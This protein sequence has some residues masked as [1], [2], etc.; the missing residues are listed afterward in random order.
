MSPAAARP[1]H[2]AG[3]WYPSNPTAL[4]AQL[5]AAIPK[6][7]TPTPAKAVI[8]PHA[9]YVYSLAIA[10]ETYAQVTI[11]KT[12]IVLCP[13]HTGTPP[14]L[15]VWAR[16][17][18]ETPLGDVPVDAALAQ[19]LLAECPDAVASTAPHERE[20]AI[21]LHLPILRFLQPDLRV[22]PVVV[23]T[24]D[25][26]SLS[27][28][29]DALA[30]AIGDRDDVLLVASTDMTHFKSAEVAEAQDK[31]ALAHV[32]DLD[33]AGLLDRCVREKITMCGV[34]PTTAVLVAAK[35]LGATAAELIRYGNSGETSGDTARVVGYAGVVIR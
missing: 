12:V 9:G 26:E 23:A 20:H 19:R 15:S 8:A 2:F 18:W 1:A 13:N 16:G 6:G 34:R 21:E 32:L 22:V 4:L 3:S 5:E 24:P 14:R 35:A 17:A 28:L 10:A 27:T 33:A 30:R 31:R 29:G 11:P 25:L 7:V